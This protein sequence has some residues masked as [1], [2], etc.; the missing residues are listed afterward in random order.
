MAN[1]DLEI[2][3]KMRRIMLDRQ[4]SG[5][6]QFKGL[7]NKSHNVDYTLIISDRKD[8]EGVPTAFVN[9]RDLALS[10]DLYETFNTALMESRQLLEG[11]IETIA[12]NM[13]M[14][15]IGMCGGYSRDFDP[16][17]LLKI[18]G[19]IDHRY[20][21]ELS[22]EGP[23]YKIPGGFEIEGKFNIEQLFMELP[24]ESLLY[25]KR[26]LQGKP[27]QKKQI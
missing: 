4:Y 5:S 12:Q 17:V 1:K 25:L 11:R 22:S 18:D 16:R 2:T 23:D 13:Q 21:K 26:K 8:K 6:I 14:G 27:V 15:E 24:E 7:D 20:L 19:Q 9:L 3:V 10:E